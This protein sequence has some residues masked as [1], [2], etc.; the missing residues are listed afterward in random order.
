M[1]Q[2]MGGV[3]LLSNGLSFLVWIV[4]KVNSNQNRLFVVAVSLSYTLDTIY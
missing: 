3:N 4:N 1:V 2:L